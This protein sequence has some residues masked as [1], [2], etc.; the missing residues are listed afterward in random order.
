MKNYKKHI[1]DFFRE[2]LGRY[3]ETPPPDVWEGLQGQLDTLKPHVPATAPYR[4]LR[5]F[6][7]VS[8]I[9]I[10]GV[11]L[12]R[13]LTKDNAGAKPIAAE[14]PAVAANANAAVP[15]TAEAATSVAQ[16][17][18]ATTPASNAH[19]VTATQ[20]MAAQNRH[21][22]PSAAATGLHAS[23]SN[24]PGISST[25]NRIAAK[26][27]NRRPAHVYAS[28]GNNMDMAVYQNEYERRLAEELISY[29]ARVESESTAKQTEHV[30]A[31][32]TEQNAAGPQNKVKNETF[33]EIRKKTQEIITQYQKSKAGIS[34]FAF[35][36]KAGYE[37]G[38][39]KDAANKWV[40]SPYVT[41]DLSSKLSI[42]VQPAI[43]YATI[44]N[45]TLGSDTYYSVNSESSIVSVTEGQSYAA[46]GSIYYPSTYHYTQS[47][48]SIVKTSTI[49]GSYMELELPVML[50]YRLCNNLSVYGGVNMLYS[51]T[52]SVTE[53]MYTQSGIV[54][55]ADVAVVSEDN[56]GSGPSINDVFNYT[57]TAYDG[58]GAAQTQE[59]SKLRAGYMIGVSYTCKSR[60]LID[61]LVQQSPIKP[62]TKQ[63]YNVNA[64]LSSPYL[65]LTL[66]YKLTK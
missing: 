22:D 45:R 65:R 66:G 17:S 60:W 20:S 58:S 51:K 56:Y 32:A 50:Q 26:A 31:S 35:G 18:A 40:I 16:G 1:D 55:N 46:G 54:R 3:R 30:L 33:A 48:D 59:S 14:Q 28:A 9:A 12:T 29:P 62:N 21:N 27:N 36:V 15:V 2:K 6:G 10:L 61:A 39:N 8:L 24:T 47:H 38:F 41:Y 7:M 34:K 19:A 49:G 57:G 44:A 52:T 13:K 63:G 53:R 42:L 37:F 23:T 64:P 43:K 11:S 5:H 4:W 25:A